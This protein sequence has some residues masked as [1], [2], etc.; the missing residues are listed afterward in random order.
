[1]VHSRGALL[2]LDAIQGLGV[3]P[4]DVSRSPIDF[5]AADGHKWLLGPEG[6]GIFYIRRELLER[7]HPVGIGWNSVVGANDFS[8][9]DFTLKPHAGRYESGTMNVAGI[10]SLGASLEL[11]LEIGID[12][13]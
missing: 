5:L 2:F 4:L 3:F 11:F 12:K 10:H 8:R 13:I 1:M 9:I 7:L 6:A